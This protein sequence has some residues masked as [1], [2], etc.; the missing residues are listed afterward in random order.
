MLESELLLPASTANSFLP[1]IK[2]SL[3]RCG[4]TVAGCLDDGGSVLVHCHDRG[5]LVNVKYPPTTKQKLAAAN[6]HSTATLILQRNKWEAV[7]QHLTKLPFIVAATTATCGVKASSLFFC[8]C[9]ILRQFCCG[10]VHL[11]LKNSFFLLL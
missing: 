1:P 2:T 11:L 6:M 10:E 8:S 4:G 3:V 5:H 9:K 7:L